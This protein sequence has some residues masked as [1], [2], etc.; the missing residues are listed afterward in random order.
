MPLDQNALISVFNEKTYKLSAHASDRAVKRDIDAFEIEEAV[1]A[2][3]II[4]D[5]P[6]DT[7]G[8][9]CLIVGKTKASA[10]QSHHRV[11]AFP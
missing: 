1:I 11:R 8:P 3:E 9:S 10:C 4:E 2:G 6:D 5:Y 7:Y